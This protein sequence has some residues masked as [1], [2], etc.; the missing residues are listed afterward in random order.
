LWAALPIA[1]G[2]LFQTEVEWVLSRLESMGS[3]ALLLIAALIAVYIGIK[4]V[5][6]YLLIRFLRTVR[7]GVAELRQMM[8]KGGMTVILDVRSAS[9][10]K[11]DPRRIPG[12]I[13]VDMIAPELHLASVPP[14]RDVVVYCS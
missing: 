1:A 7:I 13:A 6:R 9:A 11:F 2:M 12:A 10:R 5:E 4:L 8:E 3:G 14:D